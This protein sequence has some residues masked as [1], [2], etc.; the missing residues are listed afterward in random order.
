MPFSF[1]FPVVSEFTER[2]RCKACRYQRCLSEGMFIDPRLIHKLDDRSSKVGKVIGQLIYVDTRR[3]NLLK[4][5]FTAE[6]LNLAEIVRR[7]GHVQ[8]KVKV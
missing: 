3:S 5:Q 8:F 2:P 7:R 1:L 6:D 4:N